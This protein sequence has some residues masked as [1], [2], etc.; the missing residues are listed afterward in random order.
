MIIANHVFVIKCAFEILEYEQNILNCQFVFSLTLDVIDS[1][2]GILRC[3]EML[4]E[5]Q[6]LVEMEIK[7]NFIQ[8]VIYLDGFLEEN[9]Q[10]KRLE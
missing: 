4:F 1:T 6:M 10:K 2:S 8:V 9:T 5:K 3:S 7:S